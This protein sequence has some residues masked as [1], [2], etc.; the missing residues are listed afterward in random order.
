[1]I[2]AVLVEA[3]MK[4]HDAVPAHV[5][6]AADP[7]PA[8]FGTVPCLRDLLIKYVSGHVCSTHNPI[9]GLQGLP[10]HIASSIIDY[11]LQ[12]HLLRPKTLQPFVSWSAQC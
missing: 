3:A 9:T 4:R 5:A 1:V 8:S 2:A 7:T 11:L 6:S 12:E 10:A